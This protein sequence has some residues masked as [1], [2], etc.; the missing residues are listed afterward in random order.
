MTGVVYL[1][2]KLELNHDIS[3]EEVDELVENLDYEIGDEKGL[4]QN[5]E[6]V[7]SNLTY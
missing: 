3:E 6:I 7:D 5:T 1:K 4:I 2:V